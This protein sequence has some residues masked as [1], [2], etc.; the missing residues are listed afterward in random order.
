[1]NKKIYTGITF[2]TVLIIGFYFFAN[3]QKKDSVGSV[4]EN[5]TPVTNI[6]HS[7]G[8]GLDSIVQNKVYIATHHG[9]YVLIDD[10]N[11]YKIGK[12]NDDYMGFSAHP[13]KSGTFFSSGHYSYGGN[14]GFQISKDGGIE[15]KKLS[16]GV[17]GPVDFHAMAVSPADPNVIYGWY[18]G[19]VQ[20]SI[21]GGRNWNVVND[22]TLVVQLVADIKDPNTV[23][24]TSPK[25]EGILVSKDGG[26]NWTSLSDDLK[27]GQVSAIAIN[28]KFPDQMLVYSEKLNG[29]ASSSDGGI[30]WKKLPAVFDGVVLYISFS[31]SD[32]LIVYAMIHTNALYKSADGGIT[33]KEILKA[34]S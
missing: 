5:L 7:H 14:I 29:L 31:R 34:N 20:K 33:W 13:E 8:I 30:T 15:W 19:K 21:D 28:P 25:G 22:K 4:L 18:Q 27:T 16:S 11:L 26:S 32:P 17:G 6:T 2:I 24:G 23:Y 1:M 9:L 3:S 12:S 10:K